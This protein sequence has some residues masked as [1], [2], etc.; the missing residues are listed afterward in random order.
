M[1]F[2]AALLM[3]VATSST[4]LLIT[5]LAFLP[6]VSATAPS[7]P[8]PDITFKLF[9]AFVKENFSSKISLSSVL[10][11]LFSLLDN[12][13][14]MNLH[15][16]R[17]HRIIGREPANSRWMK[18]FAD[19]LDERFSDDARILRHHSSGSLTTILHDFAG[20]LGLDSF[21][22]DGDLVSACQSVDYSS[23]EPTLIIAP[24]TFQCSAPRC[25]PR[26]LHPHTKKRDIPQVTLI[27]G[28]KEFTHAYVLG[29]K[30]GHCKTAYLAD[31][32][33]F[34]KG[35]DRKRTLFNDAKYLKVGQSLWVDR[36]FS[37]GVFNALYSLHASSQS[38]TDYYNETFFPSSYPL[39]RRHVWQAVNQESVRM[40][41]EDTNTSLTVAYSTSIDEL[42]EYAYDEMGSTGKIAVAD[43]HACMDCTH[44]WR[45]QADGDPTAVEEEG[46]WVNMRVVDG[47][48][49][50]PQHCAFPEC[51]GALSSYRGESYCDHHKRTWGH[52]CRMEGCEELKVG[53]TT[54]CEAHQGEWNKWKAAHSRSNLSGVKRMIQRSGEKMPWQEQE[55]RPDNPHDEEDQEP[56]RRKNYFS[57]ARYYCVEII[58]APCGVVEAWSLFAKSE[59][60][61][62]IMNFL[63]SVYPTPDSRPSFVCIDKACIVLKTVVHRYLGWTDTTRFIVDSYHYRNHSKKD[64]LCQRRCNPAPDDNTVPNLVI[65]DYDKNGRPVWRRAFNTQACE[66][67]NSWLASYD[68]ILKRMTIHNFNWLLHSLLF[69]HSKRVL[70]RRARKAAKAAAASADNDSASSGSDMSVDSD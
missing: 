52:I 61:T 26:S 6:L 50:G 22:N 42:V 65:R 31:H 10:L 12:P 16:R 58:C 38:Y 59:S 11:V 44:P 69:L 15:F 4:G 25:H 64:T 34:G 43:N 5:F 70:Q 51:K 35:D 21:N 62:N 67:L 13:E 53:A 33:H 57:P 9:A 48:V 54:A 32:S 18:L 8:F 49:M 41:A 24:T 63:D 60:P 40:V 14:L 27:K 1:R 29:G 46:A 23:I 66:Q 30:C 28:G 55:E 45:S 20:L 39:S 19:V 2:C 47:I 36:E 7:S 56:A 3:A 17:Q 68:P 37:S